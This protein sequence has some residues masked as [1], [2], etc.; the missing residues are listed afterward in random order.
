LA[1]S[2][3][4]D[5]PGTFPGDA[6]KPPGGQSTGAISAEAR[7]AQNCKDGGRTQVRPPSCVK[8]RLA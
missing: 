1:E 5:L 4:V 7:L 3:I 2:G 8:I 6:A